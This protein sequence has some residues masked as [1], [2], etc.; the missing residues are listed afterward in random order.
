M[1]MLSIPLV[2][3]F[4]SFLVFQWLFHHVSP[5]L[6]SWLCPAFLNLPHTHKT[7]WNIRTVSTLHALVV[8]PISLYIFLF[9][10]GVNEDLI[11]GDPTL[12]KLNIAITTGY[13]LS[14]LLVMFSSWEIT[15]DKLFVVHHL[16]ALYAYSYLLEQGVLPYFANFRLMSEFSTPCVNQRWFFKVLGYHKTS[17]PNLVNGTLMAAVFFLVRLAVLPVY[18]YRVFEV[19]GTQ[20]YHRVP[21]GARLTWMLSSLSL[22]VLNLLWMWRIWKGCLGVLRSYRR[23][24]AR[25]L[26]SSK[27]D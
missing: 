1:A 6:F 4:C 14:D 2:S 27:T 17:V 7:E 12:V 5:R 9:D 8:S 25:D 22:D 11:W 13:L 3:V 18:Y 19:Y 24:E 20:A 16:V 15:G 21:T 10:E 26:P 23:P